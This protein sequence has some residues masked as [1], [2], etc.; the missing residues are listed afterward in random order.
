MTRKPAF[1]FSSRASPKISRSTALLRHVLKDIGIVIRV[2]QIDASVIELDFNSWFTPSIG[3]E[4]H[5]KKHLVNF[6]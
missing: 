4:H 1:R 3:A 5:S 6:K 2:L